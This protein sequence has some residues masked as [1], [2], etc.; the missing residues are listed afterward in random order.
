MKNDVI[1]IQ[2]GIKDIELA[3]DVTVTYEEGVIMVTIDGQRYGYVKYPVD[4]WT[5][6]KDCIPNT[7]KDTDDIMS[8][9]KYTANLEVRPHE[10]NR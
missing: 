8:F 2:D 6:L 7:Y 1:A 4:T 9:I 10:P 3:K 5:T